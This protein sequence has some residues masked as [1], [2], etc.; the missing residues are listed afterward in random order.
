M[1][2]AAYAP[3]APAQTQAYVALSQTVAQS[4]LP[5]P[6]LHLVDLRVS[7]I[8]GCAF[9]VD[10]HAKQLKI[11]QE[12]ELRLHHLA[13]WRDS[14]LFDAREK[15]ALAWAEALTGMA[16][17]PLTQQ[18]R[19]A[20]RAAFTEEEIAALTFA[21]VTIN[22]WNRLQAGWD[23]AP[24]AMDAAFGLDRAGLA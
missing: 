9:C 5:A 20:V 16:A 2:Q 6:L 23:V 11:A 12:R 17:R 13:V 19:D 21:I 15:A 1:S 4:P 24:G 8:N 3:L 18:D 22:G 14:P 10:M 7:Q